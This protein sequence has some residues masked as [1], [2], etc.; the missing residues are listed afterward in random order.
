MIKTGQ[1]FLPPHTGTNKLTLEGYDHLTW[2]YK[3]IPYIRTDNCTDMSN[4]FSGAN[5]SLPEILDLR[6]F[7]TSHVTT[8]RSMFDN[9]MSEEILGL[10]NFNTSNV[11][12][13]AF[14]FNASKATELDLSSFD[15]S[16]VTTMRHMFSNSSVEEI[17][18]NNFNTASVTDM[19]SMFEN[20]AAEISVDNFDTSAVTTMANMFKNTS[21]TALDLSSFDTSI[22]TNME[23]M[24][25]N[26]EF[27]EINI[28]S[29]DTS[30]VTNMKDMFRI[31]RSI[32]G[33]SALD[34]SNFDMSNVTDMSYMLSGNNLDSLVSPI[35]FDASHATNI[36]GLFNK[37][38]IPSLD[39]R[40]ISFPS[41]ESQINLFS[42]LTTNTLDISDWDL[43][44][45][46]N[47]DLI[48]QDYT[49]IE[50]IFNGANI[51]ELRF[52]NSN[53]FPES[54][55]V[56]HMF[57]GYK[58]D[59]VLDVSKLSFNHSLCYGRS[60]T[61]GNRGMF[62][63]SHINTLIMG[64]VTT[65]EFA[66]NIDTGS[67]SST[68][69]GKASV[70]LLDMSNALIRI[71]YGNYFFNGLTATRINMPNWIC[72]DTQYISNV[73]TGRAKYVD[74]SSVDTRNADYTDDQW[75]AMSRYITNYN[76]V[77][78]IPSTFILNGNYTMD[79]LT[80]DVY[81][82]A[83]NH[84]ELGWSEE[85]IGAI[86]HYGT[87]HA[88]FE[89]AILDDSDE[90][91]SPTSGYPIF[92][93]HTHVPLGS[94]M[95]M[96]QFDTNY[97][98]VYL[99]DEIITEGYV[100][101]E[102][103]SFTLKV[104]VDGYPFTQTVTVVDHGTSYT[105]VGTCQDYQ[106][107]STN[108]R[109][110]YAESTKV[111]CRLYPDK[112]LFVY[113][114]GH[115]ESTQQR[116]TT[117]TVPS[118]SAVVKVSGVP[119]E[120]N[121]INFNYCSQLTDISELIICS[122]RSSGFTF[123]HGFN[124][125]SMFYSCSRLADV[126]VV[127]KWDISLYYT[128][129]YDYSGR[130][131]SRG[132][133]YTYNNMFYSTA[134]TTA[135]RIRINRGSSSV[136]YG[137]RHLTDISKLEKFTTDGDGTSNSYN[138]IFYGCSSLSNVSR[139][140]DILKFSGTYNPVSLDG[141]LYGTAV[142]N[143]DF[144]PDEGITVSSINNMFYNC[145]R[146]TDLSGMSRI[147]WSITAY[148]F[149]NA[150]YGTAAIDYSPFSNWD[151][152]FQSISMG[153][154]KMSSLSFMANW[155][156]NNCTNYEFNNCTNLTSIDTLSG[157][158][159]TTTNLSMNL[160]YCTSLSSLVGLEGCSFSTI[161]LQ[162]CTSLINLNGLQGCT[163]NNCNSLFN[164][165][166]SLSNISALSEVTFNVTNID[167]MFAGCS[168]LTNLNGIQDLDISNCTSLSSVFSGC[169]SLYDLSAIADWNPYQVRNV[170]GLFYNCRSITSF[171]A[172]HN[173]TT[174]QLTN[175][176]NTFYGC[177]SL[178]NLDGLVGF[179][180]SQCTSLAGVFSG[181]TALED[182]SDI[183]YWYVGNCTNMSQMFYRCVSLGSVSPIK[184]WSIA[185]LTNMSYMFD[186]D[187]SIADAEVLENWNNIKQMTTVSRSYA[188]RNVPKPWPSWAIS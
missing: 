17:N 53:I 151:C 160:N 33:V 43:G 77:V 172:I 117:I 129:L 115:V 64:N 56:C 161:Y 157:K 14:M 39:L 99:D 159:N 68:F 22:V 107:N 164:G 131:Q 72:I 130:A 52:S 142:T 31:D 51:H 9:C 110:D 37:V 149:A 27:E 34:I 173:W 82:D 100:F 11:E 19:S 62:A 40:G 29:F 90:W 174:S 87:T 84:S 119:F 16:N 20:T 54:Y 101:N 25:Y 42:R 61:A 78:W 103:G 63:E 179:N 128:E 150:F 177:E 148:D 105:V 137:C 36:V 126:S 41:A 65:D 155:D 188:F 152:H 136:F 88:D 104:I 145:S 184:N 26:A 171:A 5:Y 21:G 85:P 180:P 186:G 111:Q 57:C 59:G 4:M 7:N 93:C 6:A 185:R 106:W 30:A 170:Y 8:M 70:E 168:S 187:T 163:I 125:S 91:V 116:Y 86:M 102:T 144:I 141:L 165:C 178:V 46:A 3:L 15:T 92:F 76:K 134:I 60:T 166:S 32:Q 138:N 108:L 143:T 121:K 147:N 58:T 120:I 44:A 162:G 74:Y 50:S 1:V 123:T 2:R 23:G 81:T 176:N 181:C 94:S 139:L 133:Y 69:F 156:L 154:T 38:T 158:I 35:N 127:D 182:I 83:L 13:M 153:N 135:P 75:H 55:N 132:G 18:V 66:F 48:S 80:G 112:Y 114:I 45:N 28:S 140:K 122:R 183:T 73:P 95:T 109:Y 146:L 96:D 67:N 24:F 113:P 124:P 10:D 167:N 79:L 98:T 49:T 12:D 97:D 169:T 89:Q 47:N 71:R 118:S 175:M